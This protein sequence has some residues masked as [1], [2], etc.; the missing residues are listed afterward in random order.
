METISLDSAALEQLHGEQKALL[1]AIDD[2]RK[3]GIGRFVDLPQIIVVGDQSSGKS[4]VLEAISRVRFPV[5]DGLCTRFAT[6]LVLRTDSQTK[7]DVRI[8]PISGSNGETKQFDEK[9]FNKEDLPRIVEEAKKNM[10]SGD[11]GFSED[12][13]RIEISSPDVPHLT[14]VDLPGFYHSEDENQSAAGREIVDRL[15]ERYMHRK[16]SIILA[17][18][19]ARNQV[20]LQKVLSKVKEHDKDKERTLGIITKPDILIPDTQDEANFVRLAKNLDNSHKLS[21]GWHVLRNR[22]EMEASDTDEERDEKEAKFFETGLWSSVPSKNRGVAALRKKLSGILL[23]HIKKNLQGLIDS[24]EENLN[25]RKAQLQRLGEP[26]STPRELRRH[27][28]KIASQFH[29]L[30]LNAVEGNYADEFFGGLYSVTSSGKINKNRIRKLRGLVRDLNRAFAYVLETK[31]SRRIILPKDLTNRD[32]SSKPDDSTPDGLFGKITEKFTLPTFLQALADQYHFVDPEKVTFQKIASEL[33]ALSSANQG[34]EFP[35]TSNDRLAV[36]LFQD[37]AKP[38]EN[39]TRRHLQLVLGITKA[40]VE[41]LIGHLVNPDKRTFSAILVEIVD[42]F[43]EEKSTI[44][45]NKLQ[46]LLR[47]YKSGNPQPLDAEFRMLLAKRRQKDVGVDVVRDLMASRPEFF[48]EA[49]RKELAKLSP[50]KNTSEFGVD[51]LIDK[52]ETYYEMSLRTFVDNVVVLAVEN[53][54]ISD[55]PSILTT[56]KINEMEDSELERLAS[57][58][59]EVETERNELQSEYEA[60]QKGLRI[61]NKFKERKTTAMHSILV[62]S[63]VPAKTTN[64]PNTPSNPQ[65]APASYPQ[66]TPPVLFRGFGEQNL[67]S[68][69]QSSFPSSMTFGGAFGTSLFGNS[70]TTAVSPGSSTLANPSSS[71]SQ[72]PAFGTT[73]GLTSITSLFSPASTTSPLFGSK[74]TSGFGSSQTSSTASTTP[75]K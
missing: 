55:L 24:I 43:F 29:V 37:Q 5:K 25:D 75:E 12:V 62:K 52:S 69:P 17:V 64:A 51:S 40:F 36:K 9:S 49:A 44:L 61:C 53:C 19:S 4:S 16:N 70:S 33:E 46:E 41:K 56:A 3:H 23:Q 68:Q 13:L 2:L 60:L 71:T 20:I 32:N 8:L 10:V 6:E 59:P 35:G 65:A 26:R 67:A 39:I 30:C 72:S 21:L 50:F 42:P 45:E 66:Q 57:E 31:G 63:E 48:T 1:D 38:W 18:I 58:S 7:V 47:H 15:A 34:N 14:M 74:N 27:L 22:G 54:L 28:D 11:A 73:N